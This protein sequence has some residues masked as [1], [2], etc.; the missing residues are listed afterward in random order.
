[1]NLPL[2]ILIAIIPSI[3]GLKYVQVPQDF[4]LL[5]GYNWDYDIFTWWKSFTILTLSILS[6][7]FLKENSRLPK[8]IVWLTLS[9]CTLTILSSVFSLDPFLSWSGMPQYNEGAVMFVCYGIIFLVSTQINPKW[10]TPTIVISTLGIFTMCSLQIIF[11]R[12]WMN[13]FTGRSL[14]AVPWPLYG[15]LQNPNHLG[16]FVSLTFPFILASDF[17]KP[18]QWPVFT[19]ACIMLIV[20]SAS[21]L[22]LVSC[23]VTA[24][25]II[26]FSKKLY[27]IV[28][29]AIILV[30]VSFSHSYHSAYKDRLYIWQHTL[31]LLKR[32]VFLGH[33]PAVFINEFPQ[34]APGY[35]LYQG[36]SLVDRPHNIYLQVAHG[37][38]ILSLFILGAI[39]FFSLLQPAPLEYKAGIAGFLIAGCFTDSFVGV[40]PVFCF[41]LGACWTRG[42]E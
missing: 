14:N 20:G 39:V 36:D 28:P 12:S 15:S 25:L 7:G 35:E 26:G 19:T 5:P 30:G 32:T 16:L 8:A 27:L 4:R 41:L 9:F 23:G 33:G 17:K 24:S 34:T 21:R 13:L 22:A 42:N 29:L 38:G 31:P 2:L 11:G 37:T 10:V 1:M 6:T 40:T 18:W 3:V